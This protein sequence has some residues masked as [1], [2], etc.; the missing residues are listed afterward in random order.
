VEP[1]LLGVV[2]FLLAGVTGSGLTSAITRLFRRKRLMA[3]GVNEEA[4]PMVSDEA[5][6]GEAVEIA[7]A[8]GRE[9]I[10]AVRRHA[11]VGTLRLPDSEP[12]GRSTQ[13]KKRFDITFAD[14]AYGVAMIAGIAA[15]AV[16]D[17]ENQHRRIG[18]NWLQVNLALLVAPIVY[19]GIGS[20]LKISSNGAVNLSGLTIA[21][22]N[23][24]FW[25][26]IVSTAG[27]HAG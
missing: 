13:H 10:M 11:A 9:Q 1:E 14:I 16:W 18:I 24:F 2:A 25:Q 19:I 5:T 3:D 26:A 15:K 21:F 23:G 20:H 17:F 7:D 6:L 4:T 22:Q 27:K 12:S 8:D